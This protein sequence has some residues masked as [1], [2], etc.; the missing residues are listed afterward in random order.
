MIRLGLRLTVAGGRRG[1]VRLVL[2]AVGCALAALLLT[3]ALGT[4]AARHGRHARASIVEGVGAQQTRTA[5]YL[6][7]AANTFYLLPEPSTRVEVLRVAAVGAGAPRLPGTTR[8][9]APGEAIVSPRLAAELRGPDAALWRARLPWRVVGTLGRDALSTPDDRLVVVG[10]PPPRDAMRVRR[11]AQNAPPS[12]VSPNEQLAEA[13]LIGAVLAPI[14]ILV[15]VA[16]RIGAARRRERL[17]AL[18]LVGASRTQLATLGAVEAASAAI[19]GVLGAGV[20]GAAFVALVPNLHVLGM[21]TFAKDLVPTATRALV[22][23]LL[24]PGVAAAAAL[25]SLQRAPVSASPSPRRTAVPAARRLVLPA[26]GWAAFALAL[27]GRPRAGVFGGLLVMGALILLAAGVAASGPWIVDRFAGLLLGGRGGAAA[28]LAGRRLRA[29]GAAAFRPIAGVTLAVL[30]ATA[31]VVYL[32]SDE[33]RAERVGQTTPPPAPLPA[34]V[35]L[36]MT[37]GDGPGVARLLQG[38]TGVGAVTPVR[39]VAVPD[40]EKPVT[41]AV[42]DCVATARLLPALPSCRGG[43]LALDPSAPAAVDVIG[44]RVPVVAHTAASTPALLPGVGFLVDAAALPPARRRL[45]DDPLRDDVLDHRVALRTDGSPLSV[46]RVTGALLADGRRPFLEARTDDD[47]ARATTGGLRADIRLAVAVVL[48]LA[49]VGLVVAGVEA[50]VERRRTLALLAAQGTPAA[51]LRAATALETLGP[52]IAAAVVA[53][54][55]GIALAATVARLGTPGDPTDLTVP[56][57]ELATIPAA[58]LLLGG[59]VLA[60]TVPLVGRAVDPTALRAE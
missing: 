18:R 21:S 9:P 55:L 25:V 59:A 2:V 30:F 20:L 29:D 41:A 39:V 37:D 57:A 1:L 15:G 27:I 42:V 7:L 19:L 33:R 58:V 16:A 17:A 45:L 32:A 60:V 11:F 8:T 38:T 28:L 22:V 34:G 35:L 3:A 44:A 14:A 40:D 23:G 31:A 47:A 5:P 13:V 49:A 48:G 36:A 54:P 53:L 56:W 24:V 50:L 51:T 12:A 4:S 43:A 52:L 46:A 6:A 10:G 26:L